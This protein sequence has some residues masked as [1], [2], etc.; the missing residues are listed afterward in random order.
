MTSRSD[1]RRQGGFTL[2]EILVVLVVLAVLLLGAVSMARVAGGASQVL[3]NAAYKKQA[4]QASDVGV[5]SAFAAVQT[6]LDPPAAP[7]PAN[8]LTNQ[9]V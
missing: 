6:L 3:A 9:P 8:V 7:D 1:P 2:I 5:N 4:I